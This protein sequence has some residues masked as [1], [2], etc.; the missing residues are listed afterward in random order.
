MSL[1]EKKEIKLFRCEIID[2]NKDYYIGK[3]VFKNKYYIK[4]CNQNKK[5]K[6]GMDDTFYAEVMNEGIIFKR[7][8][9]YPITSKEYE[10]IF[11]KESYNEIIDKDILNKIKQM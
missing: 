3:D 10:K 7:T 2:E 5:Y 4:K 11:V 9:L 8:V 1:K 6:V